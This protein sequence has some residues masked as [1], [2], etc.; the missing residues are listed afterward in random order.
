MLNF[1]MKLK[2]RRRFSWRKRR[3]V[4]NFTLAK[5]E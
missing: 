2:I 3:A 5:E 4:S 1:R